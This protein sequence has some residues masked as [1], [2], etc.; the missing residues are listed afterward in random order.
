MSTTYHASHPVVPYDAGYTMQHSRP[1]PVVP[2]SQHHYTR[3]QSQQQQLPQLPPHSTV[4]AGYQPPTTYHA[5]Q[6]AVTVRPSVT[7]PAPAV[8]APTV[9]AS[10]AAGPSYQATRSTSPKASTS[11]VTE[12][13]GTTKSGAELLTQSSSHVPRCIN[14]NGGT[15]AD[16]AADM[17][18]LFWFESV[19][20]IR[21]AKK[22][23]PRT[24]FIPALT[25][26]ARPEPGFTKW[27]SGILSTTQVT[28]NVIVLALLFIYRLKMANP[29]VRGRPGSEYR[30]LT[31][32]L[33]LGNKFL[34]DNTYTNKTWADVSQIQVS[35]IHVMEVEF[36]SNMRYNLLVTAEEWEQWLKTMANFVQYC[37]RAGEKPVMSPIL[38][39]PSPTAV[40][41]SPSQNMF[42][43]PL[44][45]PTN[46]ISQMP[47]TLPPP[48]RTSSVAY[49]PNPVLPNP[50][51]RHNLHPASSPLS[52][53]CSP[54]PSR[55]RS[56][57]EE[58]VDYPAKRA[59]RQGPS[60]GM[61]MA[62][63][64]PGSSTNGSLPAQPMRLPMPNLTVVTNPITTTQPSYIPSTT[65]PAGPLAS[66]Y[67]T[68]Q[69]SLPPL[70]HG[71]RAMSTVYPPVSSVAQ[72]AIPVTTVATSIPVT[73]APMQQ[74]APSVLS[75]AGSV[76][77]RTPTKHH[78]PAAHGAYAALSPLND[79]F[80]PPSLHTPAVHTPVTHSPIVYL[81]DRS[82]P[83]KPVRNVNRLLYPPSASLNDYHMSLQ[84]SQMHYQPLGR[85]NDLRT[86]VVPDFVLT[87]GRTAALHQNHA[88]TQGRHPYSSQ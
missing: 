70:G 31:V 59:A 57:D 79:S 72:Q 77:Y 67:A 41:P 1:R 83:Y 36:L 7:I 35:E 2:P 81:H 16:L 66:S 71:I 17:T 14:P 60:M 21:A 38:A 55:K 62:S 82:S 39:L 32:A 80:P 64:R 34:D 24:E 48:T 29:A 61:G 30:L 69:T 78:S 6:P 28:Q 12:R 33:M 44:P 75:E 11:T 18:C 53:E 5:Q 40:I 43:S 74:Y 10:Y 23:Q 4:T 65:A 26:Y 20:V 19:E 54:T 51:I 15:M 85:R 76:G 42:S 58:T 9:P 37:Q 73:T 56:L 84:P 87:P 50:T 46:L 3:P 8:P 52:V 45:S 47:Q 25:S 88:Q 68:T 27:V 13:R 63:I 86:G 49:P 22:V